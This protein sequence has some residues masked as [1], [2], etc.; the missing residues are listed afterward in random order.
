MYERQG[1]VNDV[2]T[3][4][5][6]D[7]LDVRTWPGFRQAYDYLR[8]KLTE[9]YTLPA[10]IGALKRRAG[11]LLG[12]AQQKGAATAAGEVARIVE[13]LPEVE[14]RHGVTSGQVAE[15]MSASKEAGLGAIPFLAISLIMTAAAGIKWLLDRVKNDER[16][17][18]MIEKGLLTPEEAAAL[19]GAGL[20]PKI[21]LAG[22]LALPLAI[23]AGALFLFSRR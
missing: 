22:G 11:A 15:A 7:W 19:N 3:G 5:G 17:L 23:G 10:R 2:Y 14:R 21:K 20:L 6:L 1:L 18:D 8:G 4:L 16:K 13:G 9:F 12:V